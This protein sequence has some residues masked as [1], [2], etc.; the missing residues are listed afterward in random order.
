MVTVSSR[1]DVSEL[2]YED[3][4]FYALV[5]GYYGRARGAVA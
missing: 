4:A 2:L 3:K 1:L 5:R